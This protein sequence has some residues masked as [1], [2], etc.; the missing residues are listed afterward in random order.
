MRTNIFKS[1]FFLAI[2]V[3][4]SCTSE[5][6]MPEVSKVSF[7]L[8]TLDPTSDILIQGG[9]LHGK[10]NIDMYYKDYPVDSRVVVAMNGNY[11]NTK[12]LTASLKTF[13][14]AQT[15]TDAQLITLFGLTS[16]NP[17]DY[18]EVGLDVEMQDSKWYPAFNPSGVAYGSGPMTLPGA[19]PVIKF[20]AVCALDL[21]DFVGTAT[22]VDAYWYGGTYNAAMVKVDDTHLKIVQFSGFTG[23]LILTINKA[24]QTVTVAKQVFDTN[25]AIWGMAQYTNP[26][27]AGKGEID[28]CHKKIAL[29]LEYTVDQGSFGSGSVDISL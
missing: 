15:L 8:I 18:F 7:P 20:K 9:V 1:I 26:A 29:T 17:G 24:T 5:V 10:F 19:S 23:D 2:I 11:T 14:S 16:I 21:N 3:L 25:L 27:A 28:A 13:P 6:R 4:S 12:V 22:I